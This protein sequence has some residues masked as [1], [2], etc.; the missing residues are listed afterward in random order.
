MTGSRAPHLF[1]TFELRGRTLSNRIVLSPMC[2]YSALDG[3]PT[4]WHQDHHALYALGGVGLGIVEATAVEARGRLS[5]GCTGLWDDAHVA[6]MKALSNIYHRHGKLAGVQ[7]AHSGRKGSC[8]RS[9]DGD[10]PLG[11]EDLDR[12]DQAWQ[13][14][15]PTALAIDSSWPIPHELNLTEIARVVEAWGQ[16]A[17]RAHEADFDV[18]EIHGAHGY[19]IHQF[20]S[21]IANRRTDRY[22]GSQANRIRFAVEVTESVRAHWPAEKPLFFRVSA[23]DGVSGGWDM[24]DT[25]VLAKALKQAG[26]DLIDC[27]SGAILD[28]I[29]PQIVSVGLGY[30]VR[31]A[32]QVRVAADIPTMAVGLIVQARQAEAI[33]RDGKCD[34]VALGRTL[35]SDPFWPLNAAQTLGADPEFNLWPR[36]YQESVGKWRRKNSA[37]RHD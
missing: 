13:T 26:V 27:S 10:A 34:L 6:P 9:W 16:A 29:D 28:W 21:P 31:Y 33:I 1:S 25:I 14:I 2:Q 15:A 36:Q 20:L 7:L 3:A 12:G 17:R 23:V 19:L 30:Q 11:P 8:S 4:R 18:I 37:V 35:L 24:S 32:E 5:H 22:G